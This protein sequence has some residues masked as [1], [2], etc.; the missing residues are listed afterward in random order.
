MTERITTGRTTIERAGRMSP[1]RSAGRATALAVVTAT[2]AAASAFAVVT[3]AEA[4]TTTVVTRTF[5]TVGTGTVTIPASATG[6]SVFVVGA[7]GAPG[8]L[9]PSS[10]G[11]SGGASQVSLPD[12]FAGQTLSYLVG[13]VGGG[14]SPRPDASTV[15]AG[16]GGSAVGTADSL[17]AVAGG[18]G[19]GAVVWSLPTGGS[20]GGAGGV[21]LSP[22]AVG[23]GSA[24][25]AAVPGSRAPGGGG[26]TVGGATDPGAS[27]AG[28][29]AQ[30]GQAGSSGP[31]SVSAGVISLA[32]G[33]YSGYLGG[34]GGSGYTG[35]A[36]G[37]TDVVAG[38][39]GF[40]SD[41]GAGGG[42][43]GYLASIAGVTASALSPNPGDGYVAFRYTVPTATA[44]GTSAT[45]AFGTPVTIPVDV[46]NA[47]GISLGSTP[48]HGTAQVSGM[49]L[50]YTPA[51]GFSGSDSFSYVANGPSGTTPAATVT[52]TVSAPALQFTS[53]L[54]AAVVGQP[55]TASVAAT[56]G[57]SPY[58]YTVLGSLPGGLSLDR[59]TGAIT[60]TPTTA[61]SRGFQ[62][63][64]IDSSSPVA[65]ATG[66][67]FTIAV[68]SS[69]IVVPA[70]VTSGSALTVT[71]VDLQPG[72]YSVVL[73]SDPIVL[74]STT[75]PA[76]G[77]LSFSAT[78]PA[79]VAPG[80]HTVQ[81]LSG[82]T[83]IASA[84]LTVTAASAPAALAA[85][86]SDLG[87]PIGIAV[88]LLVSGVT[89]V[90][91]RRRRAAR[92]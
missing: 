16:G 92:S 21:S 74:G 5:S 26:T 40:E 41:S 75:V 35:G 73:H 42:G 56:G 66:G 59:S 15:S 86:G 82:S 88:L 6:I 48:S 18:G 10:P 39:S 45:T 8:S 12:S 87:T 37:T 3:P 1:R 23:D 77:V 17:I 38:P 47:W 44:A 33:G 89:A 25:D 2:I 79:S 72:T 61:G 64:A 90:A 36:G 80:A 63:L 4:A 57:T 76:S 58:A 11:G 14:S 13:G 31:A 7:A 46:T 81:L 52:V 67:P 69:A 27:G 9:P 60:G 83:V 54:P 34:S 22:G 20:A 84:A 70:S 30:G 43:S 24:G 32:I 68:Y 85:T 50:L 62:V 28:S 91:L 19:G 55:Y 53:S 78:V 29:S 51:P 71:G 49:D 65:T